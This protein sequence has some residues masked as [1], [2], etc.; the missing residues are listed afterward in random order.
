MSATLHKPSAT[1]HRSPVPADEPLSLLRAM[2]E[3][4]FAV[5]TS[6]L[7]ELTICGRLPGHGGHDPRA[8]D[9]L[10][11]AARQG[12]ADTAQALRRM[13][14]GTYGTCEGCRRPIPLGR[15]RA[16]PHARRC[17]VCDANRQ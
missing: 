13:S 11:A 1:P 10:A 8:L 17:S 9:G 14:D 2:L 4:R 16:V 6:R 3:E 12:I 7:T 15:L 5:H